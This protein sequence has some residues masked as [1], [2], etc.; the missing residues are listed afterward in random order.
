MR[1]GISKIA[2]FTFFRKNNVTRINT[3]MFENFMTKKNK[4]GVRMGA[5]TLT[6]YNVQELFLIDFES[7]ISKNI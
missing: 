5:A 7:F 3:S 6:T 1:A 4:M 2:I